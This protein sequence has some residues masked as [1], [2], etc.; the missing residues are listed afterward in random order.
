MPEYRGY[1]L[2]NWLDI[3]DLRAKLPVINGYGGGEERNFQSC[4]G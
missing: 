1:D 3:D 4:L 2:Q